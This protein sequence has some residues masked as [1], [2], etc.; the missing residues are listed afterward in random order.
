MPKFMGFFKSGGNKKNVLNVTL[1][2]VFLW[3][4]GYGGPGF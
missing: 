1:T 4:Y 2:T 3:I